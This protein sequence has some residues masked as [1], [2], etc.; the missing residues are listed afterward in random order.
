MP[1]VFFHILF[2]V[3]D[4]VYKVLHTQRAYGRVQQHLIRTG[5]KNVSAKD[6]FKGIYYAGIDSY[7]LLL[8]IPKVTNKVIFRNEDVIKAT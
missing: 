3:V 7:R 1:D 4:P 6:V 2:H 5:I 8:Q